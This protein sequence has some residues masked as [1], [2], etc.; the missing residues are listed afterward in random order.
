MLEDLA[1]IMRIPDFLRRV[2]RV[3]DRAFAIYQPPDGTPLTL[4]SSSPGDGVVDFGFRWSDPQSLIQVFL[5]LSW[6]ELGHDPIWEVRVEANSADLA[7]H[8]RAG[9]WHRLAARR[10]DSRFNE[11][12]RFWQEDEPTSCLL[13]GASAAATRFFEEEDPERMAADYLAAA[14]YSL[15]ATGA[16]PAILEVAKEAVGGGHFGNTAPGH[17]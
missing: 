9:N 13:F 8:L 4:V 17:G 14:L 12:D 6:G 11:W 2:R 10:A 7:N 1:A 16:V 3:L 5:G 15:I